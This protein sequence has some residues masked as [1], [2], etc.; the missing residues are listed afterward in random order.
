MKRPA[1]M[2]SPGKIVAVCAMLTLFSL[3][4]GIAQAEYPERT[5]M[6]VIAFDPGGP[7]D[8]TTRVLGTGGE[9]ELGKAIVQENKGGGGGTVALALIAN[10]KPDGYTLVAAPNVSVVDTPLMQRVT[11]KPLKSFT[12]IIGHSAAEHTALLVKSDAPWKTFKEFVDYAKQAPGKVKY[13]TAGVGTGMHVAMEIIAKKEG[14]KWVHVPYKGAAPALTALLGGHVDACSA[15]I[16]YQPHVIAGAVRV[17][18]DHGRKRQ[19]AFPDV[20]TLMELGYDFYNDTVHAI[21]GPAGLPQD[22]VKKLEGAFAK[23]MEAPEF[24]VAQE[25]FYLNPVYFGSAAYE[26]HLKEKWV[27]TEKAFKELG[28]IKEPATQPQ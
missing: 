18:A 16:G 3:L 4:E 2:T 26:R 24:K 10:A 23:A 8:M 9:K 22:I 19:T 1:G 15:G 21:L 28:I 27:R 13:S 20:P 6:I 25:K 14:L 7:S 17:L 12:P 11:F 5:V